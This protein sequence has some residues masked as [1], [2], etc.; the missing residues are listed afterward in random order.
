[1]KKKPLSEKP[2]EPKPKTAL[3]PTLS[4]KASTS[5]TASPSKWIRI[6]RPFPLPASVK[7]VLEKIDHAGHIAYVVGGSVRDFLLGRETKDHDI[8]TSANPDELC[9]IFTNA[10][11]VGKI[12]GVIRVPY[13][14]Q[15]IE[16]AT[17][18]QDLDYRDHRHP[19]KVVF[20]S[21]E[22]DAQRR[23]FTVNALFYD[24]KTSRIL[25]TVEGMNALRE[26]SICAIGNPTHRFKEDALR[27]LR[28]V[29]FSAE[30][31]FILEEYTAL[32]IEQHARLITKISGERVRDEL[33]LMLTGSHPAEAFRLLSSTG[34]FPW[35]LPE[36]SH[37]KPT[38]GMWTYLVKAL[39]ALS[40]QS[41][42]RSSAVAWATL[43]H[44]AGK[45]ATNKKIDSEA[46]TAAH[47][48]L[49]QKISDRLK[50]PGELIDS[51]CLLITEQP[52]FREVFEMRESTLQRFIRQPKF[53]ELLALHRAVAIA[54]DG[55]LAFYE[56][57]Q[58][59]YAEFLKSPGMDAKKFLTGEDL[60]QM[61]F[62]PG[63]KFS[64]ILRTVEDLA[65]ELKITSKQEALDYVLQHFVG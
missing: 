28:A 34:L 9:E 35:V 60:I 22:D 3:K 29:R 11:T 62:S 1:M 24:P 46:L 39:D 26:K 40:R 58:S 48:A 36:I 15:V 43:L 10:V 44:E 18:R 59:R 12:F 37:F 7:D 6:D 31:N 41:P 61:G 8:A 49:V 30:L 51:I 17:F 19:E 25:D 57:A 32:A 53:A 13:P 64:Q 20:S 33:T 21:P 23:D 52:K 16:V 65:L 50:M 56:F 54:S 4:S 45:T 63:P 55:N 27:L 2:K 14:D 38:G 42:R 5:S 47:L